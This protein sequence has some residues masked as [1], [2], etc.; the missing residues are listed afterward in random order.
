MNLGHSGLSRGR[1]L[2]RRDSEPRPEC[3]SRFRVRICFAVASRTDPRPGGDDARLVET[4]KPG[5]QRRS[6]AGRWEQQ[7]DTEVDQRA[8]QL[9]AAFAA[10]RASRRFP[11]DSYCIG[12]NPK[13]RQSCRYP[14]HRGDRRQASRGVQRR[15]QVTKASRARL[16]GTPR[17]LGRL[18]LLLDGAPGWHLTVASVT[19]RP[20]QAGRL[21]VRPSPVPDPTSS[22]VV[23]G[24]VGVRPA[25]SV[26]DGLWC[27]A[28][29]EVD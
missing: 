28:A 21:T 22:A 7:A 27:A 15:T 24:R 14:G 4:P 12:D 17:R 25:G 10:D 29:C 2:I 3:G 5:C 8:A 20:V 11:A 1:L 13:A 18:E 16:I 23:A 26:T 9:D 6:W 19:N